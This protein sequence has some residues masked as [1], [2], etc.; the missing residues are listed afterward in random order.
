MR[1]TC[2]TCGTDFGVDSQRISPVGAS[3]P[4]PSCGTQVLVGGLDLELALDLPEELPGESGFAAAPAPAVPQP[5]EPGPGI[6]SAPTLTDGAVIA[7]P[8]PDDLDDIN[9]RTLV[10]RQRRP[11]EET[12][13]GVKLPGE[14]SVARPPGGALVFSRSASQPWRTYVGWG[15]IITASMIAAGVI[16]FVRTRPPPPPELPNPLVERAAQWR[17]TEKPGLPSIEA[18]VLVAQRGL[19]ARTSAGLHAAYDAARSA[20]LIDAEDVGAVSIYAAVQARWP[21]SIDPELLDET[22][23]GITAAIGDAPRSELRPELEE[24]RALLLLRAG[25]FDSARQAGARALELSP[26]RPQTRMVAAAVEIPIRPEEAA[27]KLEELARDATVAREAR[28]WLGEALLARGEVARAV[29]SWEQSVAGAEPD[30]EALR[31]LARFHAD[32]GDYDEALESLERMSAAGWAFAEDE[33][34]RARILARVLRRP[35]PAL[36]ALDAG[37]AQQHVSP[38]NLARLLAEKVSVAVSTGQRLATDAE[39]SAWLDRGFELAPDLPELLYAAGLADL[40]GGATERAIESLEAAQGLAPEQPEVALMLAWLLRKSDARAAAEVVATAARESAEYVPLH[41]LDALLA[42]DAG[43]RTRAITSVRRAMMHDPVAYEQRNALGPFVEP[44]A[45]ALGVARALSTIGAQEHNPVFMSAAAVAFIAA[46]DGGR[47]AQLL[48][49]AMRE[50]PRDVGVRL[51]SGML[52]LRRGKRPQARVDL[53]AAAEA[54]RRH[55]LVRLYLAR[56][57][58]QLGRWPEAL[59]VYRDLVEQ[60]PLNSAARVGLARA[61]VATGDPAAGHEEA[62]RVLDMRARDREALRLLL[63]RAQASTARR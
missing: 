12:Q 25:R 15:L 60:N 17:E 2:S 43:E 4:C 7:E 31:R 39:I 6:A 21:D 24:S 46:G 18:A 30:V 42:L 41:L 49:R 8:P 1:V 62:R 52:N 33:L 34:L 59:R 13:P 36:D 45:A 22:L 61:L 5:A 38:L 14:P 40:R 11:V 57:A 16:E 37:L 47:A 58:E 9:E 3:L 50:D 63:G 28:V 53:L 48:A 23:G 26:A 19:A 27:A 55:V 20:L 54:D 44:T 29:Q 51:Y 10:V 56:V 32:L 35:K